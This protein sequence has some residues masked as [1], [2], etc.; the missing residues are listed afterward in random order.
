MPRGFDEAVQCCTCATCFHLL[1]LFSRL[2]NSVFHLD[3]GDSRIT[4]TMVVTTP[5]ISIHT[6]LSVGEPVKNRATSE[7]N[8]SMAMTPKTISTMPPARSASENALFMIGSFPVSVLVLDSAVPGRVLSRFPLFSSF[9]L[10][11]VLA[12]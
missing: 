6:A 1:S 3:P 2:Q 8:E 5:P 9:V 7:L 12:R 4:P 11:G 10:H